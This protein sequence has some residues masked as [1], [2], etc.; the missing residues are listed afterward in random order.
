[1]NKF[2]HSIATPIGPLTITTNGQALLSLTL[3]PTLNIDPLNTLP[4]QIKTEIL[5]YFTQRN[6]TFTTP[7]L[8]E[9]SPFQ[10]KVWHALLKIPYGEVRSYLDIAKAIKMP[11]AVR[12][13]ANAIGTN[14]IS[15]IVPCHRVIRSNGHI[16][17]YAFGIDKK[18]WLLKHEGILL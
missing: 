5:L 1:M 6:K 18:N 13:V 10:L 2:I 15:I 4:E 12:A 8:L 16:G 9:G 11:T 7:I 17:G 3:S 14:P